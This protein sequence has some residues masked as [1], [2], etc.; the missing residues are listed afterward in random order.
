MIKQSGQKIIKVYTQTDTSKRK[1]MKKNSKLGDKA[2]TLVTKGRLHP[3]YLEKVQ[4][5]KSKD[6]ESFRSFFERTKSS[7]SKQNDPELT[8][9]S[10]F[11]SNTIFWDKQTINYVWTKLKNVKKKVKERIKNDYEK[12]I[13]AIKNGEEDYVLKILG[14]DRFKQFYRNK[15]ALYPSDIFLE[16]MVENCQFNLLLKIIKD[17][18]YQFKEDFIFNFLYRGLRKIRG[19]LETKVSSNKLVHNK[20]SNKYELLRHINSEIDFPKKFVILENIV[21]S[22]LYPKKTEKI[23]IIAWYLANCRYYTIFKNLIADNIGIFN[24]E[25]TQFNSFHSNDSILSFGNDIEQFLKTLEYCLKMDFEKLAIVFLEGNKEI[26]NQELV[27]TIAVAAQTESMEFLK[28]IWEREVVENDYAKTFSMKAG[29]KYVS[30]KNHNHKNNS[31]I[32]TNIKEERRD[33][34]ANKIFKASFSINNVLKILMNKEKDPDSLARINGELSKMIFWKNIQNDPTLINSLFQYNCFEQISLLTSILPEDLFSKPDYFR[35][36]IYKKV[37]ELILYFVRKTEC[38]HVLAESKIQEYIVKEYT[39]YGDKLYYAAEMLQY[40]YKNQWKRDLTKELCKNIMKNIKTKDI[41][42][43][44][45]PILTCLLLC[46]FIEQIKEVSSINASRCEKLTAELK[47]YCKNIQESNQQTSYIEYLMLQK[48][49]RER[50]AFVITSE[51][52]IFSLLETPEIGTIVKKMWDGKLSKNS[53][54]SAS[55]MHRY[56]REE[57]P[58]EPFSSFDVFDLNKVFTFQ[59]NAW[60]DSCSMRFFPFGIIVILSVINYNVFIYLLSA[61]G[62]ILNTY[63]EFSDALRYMLNCHLV[64]ITLLVYHNFVFLLFL[65]KTKRRIIFD[66]WVF[67]DFLICIFGWFIVL[68]PRKVVDAYNQKNIPYTLNV[69]VN[70][71]QVSFLKELHNE[72]D[73]Y[74][75]SKAFTIRVVI[76]VINDFLVWIKIFSVLL[77]FREMGP[78]IRMI[79]SM[80]KLLGKYLIIIAL[81]LSA[82]AAFF[83]AIF[84]NESVGFASFSTSIVT[85][86]GG[87]LNTF[88]LHDFSDSY[89]GFGSVL[90]MIYL[91]ISGVLLVNLIIAILSNVYENMAN[92]VDATHRAELIQYFRKYKWDEN[93]GYLIFLYSPF[94]LIIPFF[95]PLKLCI[96]DKKKYNIIVTK[97]VYIMFYFPVLLIIFMI[98]TA[99]LI[100]ICY[101]RGCLIMLKY[102]TLLK[103]STM[104]KILYNLKWIFC[105]FF[106]LLYV[107]FRDIFYCI[108]TVFVEN[109][110]KISELKRIKK[111]ISNEDVIIFLKFIHS[112]IKPEDKKD[113]HTLFLA[114]LY[115][116]SNE[117]AQ[118][119]EELK[120]RNE[121]LKKVDH[122]KLDKKVMLVE[123]ISEGENASKAYTS[124]I[125]KNLMILEIL[126]NFVVEKDFGVKYVELE[127]M[128]KLLPQSVVIHNSHLRRLIYNNVHALNQAMEKLKVSKNTFL[129]Y[130]IVNSII[131][132][133]QKLD[134]DLDS[135]ILNIQRIVSSPFYSNITKTKRKNSQMNQ[136]EE[137]K[138]KKFTEK[139]IHQKKQDLNIMKKYH[140]LL[141]S[142]KENVSNIIKFKKEQ[143]MQGTTQSFQS[144]LVSQTIQQLTKRSLIS[145]Q[146]VKDLQMQLTKS[147]SPRK[148]KQ[149]EITSKEIKDN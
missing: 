44:H 39:K 25:I 82:C 119:N 110:G 62:E 134:K 2:F 121:Y 146:D 139:T 67:M 95:L 138:E 86:F 22:K 108:I 49:T 133:A 3:L 61:R 8:N 141:S 69:L 88:N 28:Y 17:P 94:S 78:V 45:S 79:F 51:N 111:N 90:Y 80:G 145:N 127:T 102:Q 23:K 96:K 76:L 35:T 135:E 77:T 140:N 143:T 92:L 87:F 37:P 74:T 65:Y 104:K 112:N 13:T 9:N 105:G 60:I 91:C 46:E 136:N 68:D 93:Y 33:S 72:Y 130:Q 47:E 55:S 32:D 84:S 58:C 98:Y 116:E 41:L 81:F 101:F 7:C 123:N 117:K 124:H 14:D 34:S 42:N 120:R 97:S 99:F 12:V 29:K 131:S 19:D 26:S 21:K 114:Y 70:N 106:F 115:F 125:R 129:Q 89:L 63:S 113:I 20:N 122:T 38:R 54:Y 57:K 103:I 83:T 126:E 100:P 142:I 43:C 66:S 149:N 31:P 144:S 118:I 50:S 36:V 64:L 27:N 11:T 15:D 85:L 137:E 132:S 109:E 6:A 107:Y 40:I 10:M 56:I 75:S 71:L 1:T 4:E 147:I 52:N 5:I 30:K 53:I 148:L 16:E 18:C 73:K 128:R 48:D 24:T 59:L